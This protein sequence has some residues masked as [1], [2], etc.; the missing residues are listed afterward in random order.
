MPA[1]AR[2]NREGL[3]TASAAQREAVRRVALRTPWQRSTLVPYLLISPALLCLLTFSVLSIFVAAAVSLTNLDISGLADYSQVRFIGLHNYQAMLG[4]PAFWEALGNTAIFVGVGVPTLV[5]GSLAVAIAL[6][7]S[8]SRFFRA[9]RAFYFVPAITAIVA[10]SLIWGNLYNSQFGLLNWLLSLVGIAPVQWLTD[11]T[12]AKL[13]VALVAIWRGSG[14]DIIIFLAALQAIPQE[15]Y[16][17]AAVD[18]ASEWQKIFRITVPLM[19]FA[20]FFVTVTTLINRMQFFD[21]PYVLTSGGPVHATTSM[22]L[23]IYQQGFRYNEFG[24]ASAASIVLFAIIAAV[25]VFQLRFRQG[26][27][28]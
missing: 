18:G 6:N 28:V 4:D 5:I 17:A 11:P 12:I 24:F 13:S 1:P 3:M 26:T 14:L 7:F 22:S 19:R 2:T 16:E 20:I 8:R 25:T 10:I 9:L 21:E 23:Y 27:D 15:Y